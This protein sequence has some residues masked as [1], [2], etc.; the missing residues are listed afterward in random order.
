MSI[1]AATRQ[2]ANGG[3]DMR[4]RL[5]VSGLVHAESIPVIYELLRP[6]L[7]IILLLQEEII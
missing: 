3:R 7:I 5:R 2:K 4:M 1:T 6:C